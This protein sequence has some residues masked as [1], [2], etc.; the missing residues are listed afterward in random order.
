MSRSARASKRALRKELPEDDI[1]LKYRKRTSHTRSKYSENIYTLSNRLLI[2]YILGTRNS[3][4]ND[5]DPLEDGASTSQMN[6][7]AG[8]NHYK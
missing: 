4:K 8:I 6:Y 5:E 7:V 1:P 3:S 2:N